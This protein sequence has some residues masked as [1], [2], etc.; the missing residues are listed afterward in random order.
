MKRNGKE[1]ATTKATGTGLGLAICEGLVDGHGGTTYVNSAAGERT[2]ET[3][4]LPRTSQT[5]EV[6]QE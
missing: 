5:A 6:K 3:V 4:R 1:P 2:T